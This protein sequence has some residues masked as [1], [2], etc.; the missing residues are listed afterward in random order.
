[1][2]KIITL[3][4]VAFLVMNVAN[5][6]VLPSVPVVD[7]TIPAT[8]SDKMIANDAIKTFNALSHAEKKARIKE[9]RKIWKQNKSWLKSNAASN[10][11]EVDKVLL[12]ILA[13]LLPPLA[14]YLHEH[15]INT[16]FWISLLLSLFFWLP[17]IIYA[18]IVIL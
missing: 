10:N 18:L 8:V 11:Q 7:P 13:I 16:K 3:L 14:V 15:E 12:V 6:V 4:A 5:A 17:G 9:A 1:M 2:K